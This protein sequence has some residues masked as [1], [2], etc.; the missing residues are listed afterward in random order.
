VLTIVTQNN[1]EAVYFKELIP[2]VPFMKLLSCSLYH[3]WHNLEEEGS[4]ALGSP[5]DTKGLS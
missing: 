5:D 2:K 3:S 4:A 1:R